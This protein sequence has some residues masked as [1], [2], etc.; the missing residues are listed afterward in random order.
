MSDN[1]GMIYIIGSGLSGIA[2]A[3]AL[4]RRGHRPTIL[5][6]GLNPD[7]VA[8]R[9]KAQLAATEPEDWKPEDIAPLKRIG[10]PAANGIP[11]KLHFGSA[12][13]YQDPDL[14]TALKLQGASMY[15]SFAFGGFSNVW[16]AVIQTLPDKEFQCWPITSA[17]LAPHYTAVR[18]LLSHLFEADLP[19]RRSSAH[20]CRIR[21]STQAQALYR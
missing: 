20:P 16:G 7:P 2:A 5:D 11:R 17:E 6:A 15:R 9:L 1:D 21:P 8:R 4:V 19:R 13:P 12:F 14:A 3:A 10:P 18:A